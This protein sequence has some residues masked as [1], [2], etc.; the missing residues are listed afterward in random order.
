MQRGGSG[1]MT[2][3]RLDLGRDV[4]AN[5][6]SSNALLHQPP[7]PNRGGHQLY[8]KIGAALCKDSRD[9]PASVGESIVAKLAGG[10]VQEAFRH[11]KG[12]RQPR[13]R[14]PNHAS[15]RWSVRLWSG[16]I[17]MC[18]GGSPRGTPSRYTSNQSKSTMTPC[19]TTR[20]R[21]PRGN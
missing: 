12:I 2:V 6:S 20:L 18:G 3:E 19:R 7:V 17:C 10:N 1:K 11:L 13:R 9:C 14:S 8:R 21:Q 16:L 15:T 5:C 4:A